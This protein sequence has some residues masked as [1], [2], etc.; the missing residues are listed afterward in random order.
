MNEK[1]DACGSVLVLE[2]ISECAKT[3]SEVLLVW[4]LAA[5]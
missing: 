3:S 4:C 1:S 5:C 2:Q